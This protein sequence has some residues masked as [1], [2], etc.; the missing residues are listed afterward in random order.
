MFDRNLWREEFDNWQTWPCPTCG[1]VALTIEKKKL[2]VEETGPSARERD[3]LALL[4]EI[5]LARFVGLLVCRNPACGEVVAVSGRVRVEEDNYYDETG[6]TQT[7]H[8]EYYHPTSFSPAPPI[9]LIPEDCP[10]EVASQLKAAF[11]LIWLDVPASANRLRAGV[12]VLLTN[13]RIP[14]TSKAKSGKRVHLAL[15]QRIEKFKAKNREAADLLMAIKWIGNVG[16]HGHLDAMSRSDLL[17]GFELFESAIDLLYTKK[18]L[19]IKKM[20]AAINKR[21]G[22]SKRKTK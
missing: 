10:G 3:A 21:R 1:S 4:E 9:F 11:R 6:E 18:F 17:D 16:S 2:A 5:Y 12:E 22:R 7:N 14:Q 20:A 13:R 8:R 19:K 15:H